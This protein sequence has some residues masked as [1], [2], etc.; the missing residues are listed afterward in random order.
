MMPSVV[1][2]IAI[3]LVV[4]ALIFAKFGTDFRHDASLYML[5]L[6]FTVMGTM[7]G[8]LIYAAILN[9]PFG[10]PR[11][12]G[13]VGALVAWLWFWSHLRLFAGIGRF[14][15]NVGSAAASLA[16]RAQSRRSKAA[17]ELAETEAKIAALK[18]DPYYSAAMRE[19]ESIL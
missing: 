1:A 10:I 7:V 16:N 18:S 8:T 19:V 2:I 15:R 5:A 6:L 13:L 9:S 14:F 12:L 3:A 17:K 11:T 4:S